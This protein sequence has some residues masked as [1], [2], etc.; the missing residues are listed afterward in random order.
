MNRNTKIALGG[1]AVAAGAVAWLAARERRSDAPASY[2]PLDVLKPFAEGIW[3][4][5]SGPMIASGLSLPIRMTV[6]RLPDRSLMLHSPTRFTPALAAALAELGTVRHLIAPNIAHWTRLPAWQRAYPQATLWAAPGLGERGQVQRSGLRIDRELGAVAP[7]EWADTVE[8][9]LIAGAAGFN[10]IW[11]HH[12]PSR[13]L[14]LTDVVQH[15]EPERLPPLTALIARLSGGAAG[16]TPRY[17]RPVL[18]FG[19]GN[20]RDTATTLVALAPERV[21]FAHGRPFT[22]DA[23]AR[24][25]EAL[26][27][28]E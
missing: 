9:G 22:S 11:F 23:A 2:P 5:D 25:R 8:Q 3:I 16:T 14:V 17:L 15:M 27:W 18:R 1:A 13:T 26:A 7:P 4:T 6:I 12:R 20:L 24:L 19:A 28:V 10:E 21:V